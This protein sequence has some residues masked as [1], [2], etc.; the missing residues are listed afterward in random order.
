MPTLASLRGAASEPRDG[1]ARPKPSCLDGSGWHRRALPAHQRTANRLRDHDKI[2]QPEMREDEP[3]GI[4]KVDQHR[5][6]FDR[7]KIPRSYRVYAP[8]ALQQMQGGIDKHQEYPIADP[9]C[10]E[11]KFEI[12]AM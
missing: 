11:L 8:H 10:I 12:Y 1:S 3:V 9:A 5:K 2:Q 6:Q 7:Q 4:K